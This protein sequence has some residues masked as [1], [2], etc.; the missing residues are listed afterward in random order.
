MPSAWRLKNKIKLVTAAFSVARL[1]T[2]HSAPFPSTHVEKL[3]QYF[4]RVFPPFPS[5]ANE[6]SMSVD[7]SIT[8]WNVADLT[9]LNLADWVGVFALWTHAGWK[10]LECDEHFRTFSFAGATETVSKCYRTVGKKE[11]DEKAPQNTI[12]LY[13]EHVIKERRHSRKGTFV[14]KHF[15]SYLCARHRGELIWN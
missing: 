3:L 5:R 4:M 7:K 15:W 14:N 2:K 13:S 12:Q 1:L 9:R 10:N 6:E 8:R 11:I